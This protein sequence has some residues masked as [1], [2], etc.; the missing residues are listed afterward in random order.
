MEVP[1]EWKIRK[2]RDIHRPEGVFKDIQPLDPQDKKQLAVEV[3]A[4]QGIQLGAWHLQVVPTDEGMALMA[5]GD[6]CAVMLLCDGEVRI[7]WD[8]P[9]ALFKERMSISDKLEH[10]RKE[11]EAAQARYQAADRKEE[12]EAIAMT[13]QALQDV[14]EELQDLQD[15]EELIRG[16]G[17]GY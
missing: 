17:P 5:E 4:T 9:G 16:D 15:A 2:V 1:G 12:R 6:G 13:I 10:Y 14:L 7:S 8:G 3:M 11:L